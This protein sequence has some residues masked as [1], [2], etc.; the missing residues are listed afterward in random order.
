MELKALSDSELHESAVRAAR[1]DREAELETIAHLREIHRRRLHSV[2]GF[3]S[4]FAYAVEALG[5]SESAAAT[6]VQAMRLLDDIPST[7]KQLQS[8]E[9]SV[10][11]AA[12]AQRFFRREERENGNTIAV[13]AKK[14]IVAELA[15]KSRREVD[16][17]LFSHSANPEAHE[18]T[19]RSRPVSP[20]RT[21]LT[22]YADAELLAMIE[23]MRELKGAR[24]LE[25]LF[26]SALETE[27]QR[28]DPLRSNRADAVTFP[29][30][31][32]SRY[33]PVSI[34]RTLHR[35]SESRCEFIDPHTKRRCGS[36]FRLQ[37]DHIFPFALGGPTSLEN[38]RLLCPSHNALEARRTFGDSKLVANINS[39]R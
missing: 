37:I 33:V 8:G 28:I 27:L 26:K 5:F 3:T 12:I 39:V 13:E 29:G 14:Q 16:R 34:A 17:L 7:E 25:E 9:L 31:P 38:L 4:I 35:R 30:K 15:G 24:K 19:E 36:R 10:T 21:E 20:T 6:R 11:T 22:F 18:L 1:R 32:D 23:G 2:R